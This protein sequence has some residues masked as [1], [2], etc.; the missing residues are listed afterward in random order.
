MDSARLSRLDV[1]RHR[2]FQN[3]IEADQNKLWSALLFGRWT[4]P[5]D[6]PCGRGV[7]YLC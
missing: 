4:F 6:L 3:G 2:R 5:Q 7:K 1:L